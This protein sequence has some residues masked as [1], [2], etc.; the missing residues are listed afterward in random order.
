M[1]EVLLAAFIDSTASLGKDSSHGSIEVAEMADS[2]V[3]NSP[4]MGVG[5][6]IIVVVLCFVELCGVSLDCCT[7]CV[8]GLGMG[9]TIV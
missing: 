1:P 5:I 8:L 9:P 7:P 3:L 2:V 4:G 6:L